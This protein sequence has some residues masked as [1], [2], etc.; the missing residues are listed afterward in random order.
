MRHDSHVQNLLANLSDSKF[1]LNKIEFYL[2][3]GTE[4]KHTVPDQSLRVANI[5]QTM[6]SNADRL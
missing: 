1:T 3:N 5:V 4:G 2:N 6:R